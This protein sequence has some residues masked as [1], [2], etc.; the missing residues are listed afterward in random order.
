VIKKKFKSASV[1]SPLD[2]IQACAY[3]ALCDNDIKVV[4]L[5]GRSGTGKTKTALSIGLDLLSRNTYNKVILVR[6]AEESGKP[7]GFLKGTKDNKMVDGWSGCFI[8]NLER[9][10]DEYDFELKQGRIEV[11]SLSLLK[12][13]NFQKSFVI[14]D[15]AEDAFPEH[16]E[17]VGTRIN[18][19]S[20]LVFVGDYNQTSQIKYRNNSGIV[21]LIEKARGQEWFAAINLETNGR[22]AVANFFATAFKE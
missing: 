17:L 20:K 4:C 9:G 11:E 19:D 22:G 15:E 14:F 7:I 12:G 3:D 13:R 5:T 18:D 1:L 6:H 8:D 21:R 16:I 10:R 2:E